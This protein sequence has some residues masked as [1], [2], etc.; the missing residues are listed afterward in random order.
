M[1]ARVYGD[2]EYDDGEYDDGGHRV[3]GRYVRRERRGDDGHGYQ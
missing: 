1:S 2:G 3:N